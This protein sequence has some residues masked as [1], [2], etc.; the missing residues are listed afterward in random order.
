MEG[1][2]ARVSLYLF[3]TTFRIGATIWSR[4]HQI[5]AVFVSSGRKLRGAGKA[6]SSVSLHLSMD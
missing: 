5:M 1:P 2:P 3:Y 4:A 6:Q